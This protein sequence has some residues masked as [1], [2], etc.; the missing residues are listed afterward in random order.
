MRKRIVSDTLFFASGERASAQE[1]RFSLD[2][3]AAVTSS[4]VVLPREVVVLTNFFGTFTIDLWCNADGLK[5]TRWVAT[6]PDGSVVRFVL[7]YGAGTPVTL[8][9]LAAAGQVVSSSFG[10]VFSLLDPRYALRSELAT[11]ALTPGPQ[12]PQGF[13]GPQGVPGAVGPVGP[14]GAAGAAGTTGPQ[15][16]TGAQGPVGATG[17]VGPV[18]PK[19]DT[20]SVG[21]SGPQG[22]PGPQGPAGATGAAGAA[23][24]QGPAGVTGATGAAGAQGPSGP[25]GV[26]G[27]QGP[28]GAQGPSGAQG[29]F[30]PQGPQGPAGATGAQGPAGTPG[31][32]DHSQLLNLATGDPHPQYLSETRGDA[33]Y[34]QLGAASNTFAGHI[35]LAQGKRLYFDAGIDVFYSASNAP[36]TLEPYWGFRIFHSSGDE[37]GRSIFIVETTGELSKL[38]R[39]KRGNA[40]LEIDPKP[41][42]VRLLSSLGSSSNAQR[43]AAYDDTVWVDATDATHTARRELWL[44]NNGTVSKAVQYEV[45]GGIFYRADGSSLFVLAPSEVKV[46]AARLK[47]RGPASGDIQQWVDHA[48]NIVGRVLSDGTI[49]APGVVGPQGPAGPAG[50]NGYPVSEGRPKRAGS[51]QHFSLPSVDLTATGTT[52]IGANQIR[53]QPFTIQ[54]ATQIDQFALEVTAAGAAGTQIRVALHKA[55][56]DL[57]PTELVVDAGVAAVDVAGVKTFDVSLTLQPGRYLLGLVSDGTPTLRIF[58]GAQKFL[59]PILG[60]S[61]YL[62]TLRR[63]GVTFGPFSNPGLAWTSDGYNSSGFD[64]FIVVRAV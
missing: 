16:I 63:S 12:G 47:V 24:A 49:N 46:E 6:L 64:Y 62:Y 20:G 5:N 36:V 9:S 19:G 15:G 10:A 50:A 27:T 23:G 53:Y 58:R 13:P 60:G 56:A 40:Q 43:T 29:A 41:G 3:G 7:E 51:V 33:R 14:A 32:T 34:P 37:A 45:G 17:P 2:G 25:Q 61:P 59:N 54:T 22:I 1:V 48:G 4:E 8:R 38:A 21:A 52:A 31:T 42:V 55:D 18:G 57:Q 44:A 39:F 35:K 30:G 11:I 26:P 28:A